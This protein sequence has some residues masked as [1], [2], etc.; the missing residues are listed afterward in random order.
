MHLLFDLPI[1]EALPKDGS[2]GIGN[3]GELGR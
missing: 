2:P 1:R 3:V